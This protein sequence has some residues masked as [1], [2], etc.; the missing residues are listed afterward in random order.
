MLYK[1]LVK[2]ITRGTFEKEELTSKMDIYLL[3]NR[4]SESEYTELLS[5]MD[6]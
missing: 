6:K 1:N 5:L 3:N 4:I 2:M